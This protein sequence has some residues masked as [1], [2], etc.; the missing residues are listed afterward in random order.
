MEKCG[1]WFF[2][3]FMKP[4]ILVRDSGGRLHNELNGEKLIHTP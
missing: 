1:V 4:D 3:T 2:L